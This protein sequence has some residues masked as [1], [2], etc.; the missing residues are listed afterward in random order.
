VEAE[1][2]LANRGSEVA[3]KCTD[4]LKK[5][6]V[7]LKEVGTPGKPLDLSLLVRE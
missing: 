4:I 1:N 3:R 2:Q 7:L 6:G 5:N